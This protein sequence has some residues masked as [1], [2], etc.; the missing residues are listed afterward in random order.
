[1]SSSPPITQYYQQLIEKGKPKAVILDLVKKTPEYATELNA[2]LAHTEEIK[3]QHNLGTITNEAY[4][5]ERNRVIMGLLSFLDDINK[6]H[7]ELAARH[8]AIGDEENSAVDELIDN[9]LEFNEA[10][11]RENKNFRRAVGILFLVAIG[12]SVFVT[13]NHLEFLQEELKVIQLLGTNILLYVGIGILAI[14]ALTL[15][16]RGNLYNQHF[17]SFSKKTL[18][19]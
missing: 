6:G 13:L 11:V 10:S 15:I 9:Q 17:L 14:Y 18:K 12:F 19:R 3:R 16:I 2:L 4:Q 5:V 7:Q 1:M 8:L